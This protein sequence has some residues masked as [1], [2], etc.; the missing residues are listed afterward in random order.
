MSQPKDAL[1]APTHPDPYSF[2]AELV[3]RRPLF[4]DESSRMWIA[5][6]ARAVGAVL[7]HPACRVRPVTEPVPR[8]LGP[9]A[10][11]VFRHLV[12]MNDGPVHCPMKQAVSSFLGGFGERQVRE[13]ARRRTRLLGGPERLHSLP[14]QLPLSVV[15][16]LLGLSEDGL[17]QVAVWTGDFVRGLAPGADMDRLEAGER[18]AHGLLE[19]FRAAL[20]ADVAGPLALFARGAERFGAQ[21]REALLAN[22]IGLLSQ[23]HDATAGL[24]GNTV[25]ALLGQP[26]LRERPGLLPHILDEVLRHDAPVQNTRRFLAEDAVIEG[27]RLAAGDTV[28][29]ILAAANR[30]PALNEDPHRFDVDRKARRSFT[31]GAG[32]HACPGEALVKWMA[33]GALEELLTADPGLLRAAARGVSYV[34]SVNGR[35]PLFQREVRS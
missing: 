24:L 1:A 32:V 3:A 11:A 2:Y 30:D 33:W 10:A 34:P 25:L 4:W 6:S 8:A 16:R 31:F 29:V 13:E 5:S 9:G 26:A 35:I 12:R 23:T 27:Q 7:T 20:A 14:F 19:V 15:G 21:G 18:A 28:L 22:A 17:P